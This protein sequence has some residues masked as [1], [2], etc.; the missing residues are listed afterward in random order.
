MNDIAESIGSVAEGALVARA[1]EPDRGAGGHFHESACL[2]CGTALAGTY[3]HACGQQAHLHKT[4]GA[5]LHDL[6]HGVL[7]FEGKTWR[8]LP[9]LA[10]RPGLL[11][12]CYI[13]GHRARYVSP[14]ALFLFSVFLMFA[15]FQA[16][17]MSPPA[18]LQVPDEIGVPQQSVA[19]AGQ[20]I[21]QQRADVERRI[22]ALPANDPSREGLQAELDGLEQGEQLVTLA[23]GENGKITSRIDSFESGSPFIDH[24]IEKWRKNPSLMLYKLQANSYK[25]SWL[26]IPLS[27]PFMALIFAWRRRFGLYDHAVFVTYSLSFMTL[28]F[29]VITVLAQLG[30]PG[31][32][33]AGAALVLPILHI[34]RQLRGGYELTRFSALWRTVVLVSMIAVILVLF[35]NALIVLGAF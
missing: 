10:W 35:L 26:L 4:A 6:L 12:R 8:T 25:F 5:F 29:V 19:Q 2:N 31:G 18:D 9:V 28:L 3:C 34:Y 17:G 33:L 13:D 15:V 14:M 1:V 27:L 32:L 22:A 21:A 11:T 30:V 24:L 16:A 23:Q 7:H 20:G